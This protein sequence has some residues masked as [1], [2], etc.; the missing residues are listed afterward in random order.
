M[1]K[2]ILLIVFSVLT[3]SL[4]LFSL[5]FLLLVSH[6]SR[7]NQYFAK[8]KNFQ[9]VTYAALP[10]NTSSLSDDIT[11][12]EGRVEIVRQ[13][14]LKYKSPLEPFAP[15][16]VMTADKYDLDYRPARHGLFHKSYYSKWRG[17][18]C[19]ELGDWD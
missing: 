2:A 3:P 7:S 8:N 18:K 13:F 5:I 19:S 6:K 16:I 9:T 14:L 11:L 10:S 12:S 4:L 1:R 17:G 15:L